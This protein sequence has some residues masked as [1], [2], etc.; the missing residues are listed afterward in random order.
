MLN[1]PNIL[2]LSRIMIIPLMVITFFFDSNAVRWVA[3]GFY[4][5]ACVTDFF[6]GYLARRTNQI[7]RFG[8]FLD[9]IA[10]KLLIAAVLLLLVGFGRLTL[11]AYLPA[12]IILLREIMVSGLREYLAEIR[13]GLPVTRL[14]KFKTTAQMISL[15]FLI[16]GSAAPWWIP[17]RVIGEATLWIA[18]VLTLITGYDYLR[19]GLRYMDE[20]VPLP[21]PDTARDPHASQG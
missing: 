15:G 18:A 10:D 3:L 4:V 1:L 12:L 16:V 8:R 14:A 20:A 7:S 2:T 6:D 13:V 5:A 19:A 17:A 21:P 11:W 9:P